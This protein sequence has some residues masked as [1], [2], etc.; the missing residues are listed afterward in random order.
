MRYP[1]RDVGV[2]NSPSF[3]PVYRPHCVWRGILSL[4]VIHTG[5]ECVAAWLPAIETD[6]PILMHVLEGLGQPQSFDFHRQISDSD[7]VK[8][9]LAIDDKG[10]P[11]DNAFILFQHTIILEQVSGTWASRGMSRASKP[12]S[13]LGVLI[14]TRWVIW[15]CTEN[16]SSSQ[17]SCQSP[18]RAHWKS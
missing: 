16:S 15:Q 17:S 6:F 10:T 13:L 2:A 11:V 7:L 9:T 14:E 5:L 4:T 12:P 1:A 3:P 18:W 8:G